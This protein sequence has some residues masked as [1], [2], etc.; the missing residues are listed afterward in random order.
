MR[1]KQIQ[2]LNS[3]VRLVEY[4]VFYMLN[5]LFSS[6]LEARYLA[7]ITSLNTNFIVFLPH[8]F[9]HSGQQQDRSE[10]SIIEFINIHC[11]RFW[12]PS[13]APLIKQQLPLCADMCGSEKK[14]RSFNLFHWFQTS[15]ILRR[16]WRLWRSCRVTKRKTTSEFRT[17]YCLT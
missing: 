9:V 12:K 2:W 14:A 5:T 4:I 16:L 10:Q 11:R 17:T 6:W 1:L 13:D 3:V 15:Q 7:V 8:Q